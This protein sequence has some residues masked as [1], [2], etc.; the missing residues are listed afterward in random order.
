MEA[1]CVCACKGYQVRL[2]EKE[3][4]LGGMARLASIVE[5]KKEFS[6]VVEFLENQLKMLK[7]DV[8]LNEEVTTQAVKD[9]NFDE[10]IVATGSLPV[11]P[12][13]LCIGACDVRLAKDVLKH[14][15]NVGREVV[16]LGGGSVGMEVA[17]YLHQLGKKVTVIEMMDKI[18][19]DQGPLR[20]VDMVERI[21]KTTV[22]I[23]LKTTV[24]D[25]TETGI[26]VSTDGKEHVTC[27]TCHR[28]AIMPLTAAPSAAA[29]AQ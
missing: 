22:A 18:C 21:E 19:R 5:S 26:R 15:E 10:I 13:N 6:G 20:R 3:E 24:Q 16:I 14:P 8:Q 12:G 23:M 29:P 17:E 28:G 27:Y 11:I 1:A 9:G 2:V 4:Q 7:V 25:V